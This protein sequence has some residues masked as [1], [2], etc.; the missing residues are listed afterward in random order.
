MPF[1]MQFRDREV[2]PVR[3]TYKFNLVK[4]CITRD[5]RTLN[6][7]SFDSFEQ[8]KN[9]KNTYIKKLSNNNTKLHLK[10]DHY[11]IP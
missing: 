1:C 7:K 2:V 9:M 10:C 11:L 8:L 5:E 3:H 4:L 6:Q